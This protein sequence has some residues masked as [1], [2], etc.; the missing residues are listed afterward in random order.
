MNKGNLNVKC[1]KDFHKEMCS[2]DSVLFLPDVEEGK[3]HDEELTEGDEQAGKEGWI[4]STCV[5]WK[6]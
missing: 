4:W 5:W 2:L 1:Y 3:D 6:T